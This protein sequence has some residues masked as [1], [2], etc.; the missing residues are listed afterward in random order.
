MQ[1]GSMGR[2]VPL[3]ASKDFTILKRVGSVNDL[4]SRRCLNLMSAMRNPPA[5]S[6][7]VKV[8]TK[9][10]ASLEM[11]RDFKQWYI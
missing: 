3:N 9:M 10:I 11:S 5:R 2:P 8:A 6:A 7:I 4:I 1:S